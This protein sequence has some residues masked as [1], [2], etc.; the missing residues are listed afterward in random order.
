MNLEMCIRDRLMGER[1]IQKLVLYAA[2]IVLAEALG[3]LASSIISIVIEKYDEKYQNLFSERMSKRV[4][5]LD[6]QHT[7][8]KKALDPVSYTHLDVYK[9]QIYIV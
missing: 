3:M 5:E 1:D 9:R 8:D 4:M 7:E 2:E 6:F